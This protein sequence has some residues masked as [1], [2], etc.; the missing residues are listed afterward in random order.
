MTGRGRTHRAEGAAATAAE[1]VPA[2]AGRQRAKTGTTGKS[3][4]GGAQGTAGPTDTAG[5][6]E[7]AGGTADR[8]PA[9]ATGPEAAAGSAA[10]NP[11]GSSADSCADSLDE[12]AEVTDA[13]R[14]NVDMRGKGPSEGAATE[15]APAKAAALRAGLADS[16]ARALGPAPPARLGVAVSGGG[17]SMALMH[18]M[19]GWARERGVVL[20]AATVDHGLRPA[21]RAEAEMV[22]E[23]CRSIG[24]AHSILAWQGWDGTGNLQDQA[25]RARQTLLAGW[26]RERGID[27]VA[28]AHTADDQAETFLMRLARGAGLD[29]LSAMPILRR[30]PGVAWL[31]PL[32]WARR[33]DLR[34]YLRNRG[35][36]WV[37][38]PS[39]SDP[40]FARVRTRRILDMLEPMGLDAPALRAAAE[41]LAEARRAL[42]T[43][44]AETARRIAR[45]QA[46]DVILDHAALMALPEEIRRRLLVHSLCWVASAE[47]GPR[48]AALD[49]MIARLAA[50]P[51]APATLHGCLIRRVEGDLRI[52]REPAAVRNRR[53]SAGGLWDGRWHLIP[54]RAAG[55]APPS[56]GPEPA[57]DLAELTIAALGPAGLRHCPGWRNTDLPR[58]TLLASP[59]QWRGRALEAAPLAG[60]AA[61]W[62]AVLA[63]GEA[64]YFCSL[65]SH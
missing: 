50:A 34:D 1:P 4:A 60:S 27:T 3:D 35:L 25:R 42:E 44:T 23:V 33:A 20:A 63:R 10:D 32:L 62:R 19:A 59:A 40:R 57:I 47:Y 52:G 37:E 29:G 64:E 43:V 22:A 31:R 53:V 54:A 12:P 36:G 56:E 5:L 41:R 55:A 16:L 24:V 15:G 30:V 13:V 9:S 7:M 26:A 21:A 39:N 61:G 45:V 18:L 58:D 6:T 49:A 11:T 8:R 17:D 65:L 51:R 38:D 2:G 48:Q 28:L 14:G 46:G